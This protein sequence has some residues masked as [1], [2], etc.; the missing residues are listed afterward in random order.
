MR[1][2]NISMKNEIL[3]FELRIYMI[4]FI[5]QICV[6]ENSALKRPKRKLFRNTGVENIAS[7]FP[8][9]I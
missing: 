6:H 1:V 3:I 8:V 7:V 2:K 9:S 4:I 5:N